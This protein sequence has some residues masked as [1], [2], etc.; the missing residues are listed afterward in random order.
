MVCRRLFEMVSYI[1]WRMMA[2]RRDHVS[3]STTALVFSTSVAVE[4]DGDEEGGL[5]EESM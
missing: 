3:Y 1:H 4:K 5:N 2:S